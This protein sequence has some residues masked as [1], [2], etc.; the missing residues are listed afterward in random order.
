MRRPAIPSVRKLMWTIVGIVRRSVH[1]TAARLIGLTVLPN[2]RRPT[3]TTAGIVRLQPALLVVRHIGATVS[4]SA[5]PARPTT[6]LTEPLLLTV[7]RQ[8]QPVLIFRIVHQR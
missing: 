4:R 7:V 5:R 2:V 3:R 6:A 8:M 1:R